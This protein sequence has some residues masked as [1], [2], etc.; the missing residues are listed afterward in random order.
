MECGKRKINEK[1]NRSSM[2]CGI[3]LDS[4]ICVCGIPEVEEKNCGGEEYLKK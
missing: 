4:L 3:I 1:E 2:T